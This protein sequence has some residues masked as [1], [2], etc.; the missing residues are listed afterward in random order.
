MGQLSTKQVAEKLGSS[1][2]EI[3]RLAKEI[4]SLKKVYMLSEVQVEELGMR[5]RER[6]I[7]AEQSPAVKRRGTIFVK[8]ARNRDKKH[9]TTISGEVVVIEGRKQRPR[10]GSRAAPRLSKPSK[11]SLQVSGPLAKDAPAAARA[12]A[13]PD[14]RDRQAQAASGAQA[15][16][17]VPQA[18]QARSGSQ[19]AGRQGAEQFQVTAS[20]LTAS[21]LSELLRRQKDVPETAAPS[22]SAAQAAAAPGPVPAPAGGL[23]E[24]GTDRPRT[25]DRDR[26]GRKTIT[27]DKANVESRRKQLM[28]RRIAKEEIRKQEFQRPESPQTRLVEVPESISVSE[29]AR[30]LAVKTETILAK[31]SEEGLAEVSTSNLDQETAMLIIE[32]FGHKAR[33]MAKQ[34]HKIVASAR[35]AEGKSVKSR[36][37]VVTV[38][39]H[40][41]HGKTSLLDFIRKTSVAG[42]ES[43]GIT[44]SI[45]AYKVSTGKGEMVFLDTPG[46]GV[47]TEMRTRGAAVTD[48]IVLVVAAD[49]GV[50]PQT[51]EAISHARAAQVPIAVAIS[52]TDKSGADPEKIRQQL[53]G[54]G[55]QPE[56]WGG[57]TIMIP[58]C[59]LT[60]E[61]V[62][63]LL[64]ALMLTSEMLELRAAQDVPARGTV[65]EARMEKGLGAVIN[66]IVSAGVIKKGQT[67]LCDTEHGRVRAL[68]DEN[69]VVISEAGPSTPVQIQGLS[70][71]PKV[72]C[73]FLVVESERAAR[74]YAQ[75][76]RIHERER[77]LTDVVSV[78]AD[79]DPDKWIAESDEQSRKKVLSLVLKADVAGS[80]EVLAA[81]LA[82]FDNDD[83]SVRILHQAVGG[84]TE[85]DVNLADVTSAMIIGYRVVPT[86]KVRKLIAARRIPAKFNEVIYK[87]VEEVKL[88]VEGMLEPEVKELV[89]GTAEIRK[90]YNIS[91]IGM[92][93]GCSVVD[94]VVRTKHTARVVR[95]GT[96]VNTGEIAK[97]RHF[98]SDV[99]AVEAGKECGIQLHRFA[100]FKVG[101]LIEA[102]EVTST[103]RSL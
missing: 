23:Q 7:S 59:A 6:R 17:E 42:T 9:T 35:R 51:V 21:Q 83:V 90:L 33:A 82:K 93:A 38:M 41:D 76:R 79:V 24:P 29:L 15:A 67:V 69:G 22:P 27:I 66:V 40:V 48:I 86:G 14:A 28:R 64:D 50:Q 100:D 20:Q 94:G 58:L 53:A 102:V 98:K 96:V 26:K 54:H 84:V 85:N 8:Q 99:A 101:D 80:V 81:E 87:L 52:K 57:D 11:P 36:P 103:A 3:E 68:R 13:L 44:Q 4:F 97:L 45:G 34:E 10:R 37:P 74:E 49:E 47:F 63:Q 18:E 2:G 43:G 77:R 95:D 30:R 72:G 75:S 32:E 60:G 70:A 1:L 5:L 55:L 25:R 61:G 71:L 39:G 56:E 31:M 78:L 46:H 91:K 62:D 65:I 88:V 92:I 16:L 73:E 19:V 89:V 12:P